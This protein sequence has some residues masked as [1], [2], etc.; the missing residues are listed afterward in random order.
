M[1]G[2]VS[3]QCHAVESYFVKYL[4]QIDNTVLELTRMKNPNFNRIYFLRGKWTNHTK[5]YRGIDFWGLSSQK[6]F[7]ALTI[8]FFHGLSR[9]KFWQGSRSCAR[10]VIRYSYNYQVKL[11]LMGERYF[12]LIWTSTSYF[13]KYLLFCFIPMLSMYVYVVSLN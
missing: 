13:Q 4:I 7:C 5:I 3:S 1:L 6:I 10:E 8:F 2:H 9:P 11:H 12:S